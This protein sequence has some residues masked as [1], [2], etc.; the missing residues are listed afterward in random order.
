MFNKMLLKADK[1]SNMYKLS[2]D[3]Y[4]Y[5]LTKSITTNYKKADTK[6]EDKINKEGKDVLRNHDFL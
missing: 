1:T 4:N 2:K 5:L 6:L 3:E